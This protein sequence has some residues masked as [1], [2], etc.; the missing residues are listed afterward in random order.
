MP[1]RRV[2]VLISGRGSNML[3]LAAAAQAPD[4]P[5]EIVLVLANRAQA[6]GLAAAQALGIPTA[7]VPGKAYPDRAAYDTAVTELLDAH[8]VEAIALAGFMR[9]LSAGFVQRWAGR[10]VNIHPSLLPLYPGLDTHARAIAA[11][12]AEAGCTVHLVT[13]ELD[14]GPVL[15]QARVPIEPGDTPETLA[16]RVLDAE[17]RLYPDAFARFLQTLD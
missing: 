1:R 3:A 8:G 4:W 6:P 14:A 11:R 17:H 7:V 15:A 13:E 2:A 16:A 5:G 10:M 9:I 12:D